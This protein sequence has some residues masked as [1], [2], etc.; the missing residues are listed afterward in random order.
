MATRASLACKRGNT[1]LFIF[2]GTKRLF[3]IPFPKEYDGGDPLKNLEVTVPVSDL[4]PTLAPIMVLDEHDHISSPFDLCEDTSTLTVR[5]LEFQ[6]LDSMPMPPPGSKT[7]GAKLS[8]AKIS[9][10]NSGYHYE[11]FDDAYDEAYS[12]SEDAA[13]DGND[14]AWT[15]PDDMWDE[16]HDGEGYS[17]EDAYDED[18]A[19]TTTRNVQLGHRAGSC[20]ASMASSAVSC[21][22]LVSL[23]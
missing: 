20:W 19:N 10:A 1:P 3:T 21:G 9:V 6:P 14:D 15:I 23:M 17:V 4:M 7:T 2:H 13:F 18:A 5:N 22:L 16:S 8:R 11:S 12:V